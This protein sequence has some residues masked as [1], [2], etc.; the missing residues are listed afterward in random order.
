MTFHAGTSLKD[1]CVTATG[2]RVLAITGMGADQ[3][4]AR[5]AAYDRVG[6][7]TWPNAFW[8]RDIAKS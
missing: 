5:Q 8:R 4:T 1:G 2:G 6:Q 7:I 3:P